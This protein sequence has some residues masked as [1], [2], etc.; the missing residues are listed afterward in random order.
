MNGIALGFA[1]IRLTFVTRLLERV[2]SVEL[3]STLS[4]IRPPCELSCCVGHPPQH[5]INL[6]EWDGAVRNLFG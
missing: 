1:A 4:R 2:V 6:A 3:T 5:A